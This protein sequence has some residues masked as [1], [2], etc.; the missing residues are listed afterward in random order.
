MG[1]GGFFFMN[2]SRFRSLSPVNNRITVLH[3]CRIWLYSV[4][5][6]YL[7]HFKWK[8]K[9][10]LTCRRTW[11]TWL[12]PTGWISSLVATVTTFHASSRCLS[13]ILPVEIHSVHQRPENLGKRCI[14][15]PFEWFFFA[16]RFHK[17]STLTRSY[18]FLFS[19]IRILFCT[20][21]PIVEL[22]HRTRKIRSTFCDKVTIAIMRAVYSRMGK[23]T[24]P[25]KT[26]LTHTKCQE[27]PRLPSI[28]SNMLSQAASVQ[29]ID[30]CP[31][32]CGWDFIRDLN[33]IAVRYECRLI[34]PPTC[35]H[36]KKKRNNYD[37]DFFYRHV[38]ANQS[39][40]T[41]MFACRRV[42]DRAELSVAFVCVCLFWFLVAFSLS[43]FVPMTV[44]WR[45]TLDC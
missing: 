10:C 43:V 35:L 41:G 40:A 3:L 4:W 32:I 14:F 22:P 29:I 25:N 37:N 11:Y 21:A 38:A 30:C 34:C 9:W 39:H 23:K 44:R 8:E 26:P 31:E 13:F 28:L 2:S 16:M 27:M 6:L 36:S 17:K 42:D 1:F 18:W 12:D 33:L 19:L 45:C 24:K 7:L 20:Y 5:R 15:I